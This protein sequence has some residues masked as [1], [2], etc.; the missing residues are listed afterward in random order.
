MGLDLETS[1]FLIENNSDINSLLSDKLYRI[2]LNEKPKNYNSLFGFG[3]KIINKSN[4]VIL[5]DRRDKLKQSK[6]LAFK[7][8]KLNI[9]IPTNEIYSDIDDNLFNESMFQ[10]LEHSRVLIKL[11]E[12]YNIPIFYYEDVFHT[13]NGIENISKYLNI[14]I[15][16]YSTRKWVNSLYQKQITNRKEVLL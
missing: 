5:L 14:N 11:S 9:K 1:P 13:D 2:L 3:E 8:N 6:S 4:K 7:L 12:K 15:D 10:L 16:L